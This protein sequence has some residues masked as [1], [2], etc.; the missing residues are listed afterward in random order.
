MSKHKPIRSLPLSDQLA[1]HELA[2]EI[3]APTDGILTMLEAIKR[4][5]AELKL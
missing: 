3:M 5:R 4:A 2:R 1:I